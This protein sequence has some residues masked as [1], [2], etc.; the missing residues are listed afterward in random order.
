MDKWKEIYEKFDEVKDTKTQGW[1]KQRKF[2][3]IFAE[4]YHLDPLIAS[5]MW[6]Y[7]IDTHKNDRED[8]KVYYV[9][10]IFDGIVFKNKTLKESEAVDFLMLNSERLDML[11]K[12]G[13][14]GCWHQ[15]TLLNVIIKDYLTKG[16]IDDAIAIVDYRK[17]LWIKD[18]VKYQYIEFIKS[19]PEYKENVL[20]FWGKLQEISN[21][22]VATYAEETLKFLSEA[23]FSQKA[24]DSISI[25]VNSKMVSSYVENIMSEILKVN[26]TVMKNIA[27]FTDEEGN[28][29]VEEVR[30]AIQEEH[31]KLKKQ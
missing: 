19:N 24:C 7:V 15:N 8:S 5:K 20:K 13:Y 29:K 18:E 2:S 16:K 14:E 6:Q 23:N 22:T 4:A 9:A 31:R 3:E 28:I 25:K 11:L 30:N 12:F 26:D 1:Q 27:N 21:K 17:E 10:G